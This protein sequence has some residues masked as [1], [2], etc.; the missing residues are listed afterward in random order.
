MQQPERPLRF[1]VRRLPGTAV[2]TSSFKDSSVAACSSYINQVL[3][4]NAQFELWLRNRIPASL[5][6]TSPGQ[7]DP[8]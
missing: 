1:T 4:F 7:P 3:H 6:E 5:V 8:A 2:G